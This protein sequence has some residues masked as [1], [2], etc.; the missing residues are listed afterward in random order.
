MSPRSAWIWR[1]ERDRRLRGAHARTVQADVDLDEDDD[2][3]ACADAASD[4]SPGV[5]LALDG[6]DHAAQTGDPRQLGGLH[7]P[8]DLVGDQDVSRVPR[9]P[10]R[11][12]PRSSRW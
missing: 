12:L 4:S 8:D 2:L 11:S 10:S 6:D 5:D 7:R 3:A 9:R 1:A